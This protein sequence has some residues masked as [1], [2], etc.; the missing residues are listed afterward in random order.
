M[1]SKEKCPECAHSPLLHACYE[2]GTMHLFMC[3]PL[4]ISLDP[5]DTSCKHLVRLRLINHSF[6]AVYKW[7]ISPS[8]HV[9]MNILFKHIVSLPIVH[10][11]TGVLPV[12]YTQNKLPSGLF[13]SFPKKFYKRSIRFQGKGWFICQHSH[14][15]S[16]FRQAN[17]LI[18]ERVS[19][20][21]FCFF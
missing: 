17:F 21:S 14:S 10:R 5:M 6:Y 1:T 2:W 18:R 9:Q 3:A 11:P 7:R 4:F 15:H 13:V 20:R 19:K 8:A 12:V 16:R